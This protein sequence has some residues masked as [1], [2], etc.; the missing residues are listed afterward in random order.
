MRF[1]RLKTSMLQSHV[2]V[3]RST[4]T[5]TRACVRACVRDTSPTHANLLT[6]RLHRPGGAGV[7]ARRGDCVSGGV[8]DFVRGGLCTG[9][10]CTC[11]AEVSRVCEVCNRVTPPMTPPGLQYQVHCTY[12]RV[13][14]F[15]PHLLNQPR[16]HT[17]TDTRHYMYGQQRQTPGQTAVKRTVESEQAHCAVRVCDSA[18]VCNAPEQPPQTLSKSDRHYSCLGSCLLVW[19]E[20]IPRWY[21]I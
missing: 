16:S 10:Y 21:Y 17:Q 20:F 7:P 13:S 12:E 15:F 9:Q 4:P 18:Y 11:P 19:A 6:E 5:P 2:S 1:G 3:G 14:T 8:A